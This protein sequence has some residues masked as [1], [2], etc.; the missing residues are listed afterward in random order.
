M[1]KMGHLVFPG[2]CLRTLAGWPAISGAFHCILPVLFQA[3]YPQAL[4]VPGVTQ[5]SRG[6][7]QPFYLDPTLYGKDLHE[8]AST[9]PDAEAWQLRSCP[10]GAG[11]WLALFR[12]LQV[13]SF[14]DPE[15]NGSRTFLAGH[16]LLVGCIACITKWP[17]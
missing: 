11:A 2:S 4:R 7:G 10:K 8:E 6:F 14:L 12:F 13:V 17:I 16:P 9:F 15:G 1:K 5:V 3:L